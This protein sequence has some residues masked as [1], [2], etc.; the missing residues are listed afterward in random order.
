MV[1]EGSDNS[2]CANSRSRDVSKFES[3]TQPHCMGESRTGSMGDFV[4]EYRLKFSVLITR[5]TTD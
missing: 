1:V 5:S 3:H 4:V 2:K